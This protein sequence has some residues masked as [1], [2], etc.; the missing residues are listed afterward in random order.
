METVYW[1]AVEILDTTIR[2]R[3]RVTVEY[4]TR[5]M[6]ASERLLVLLPVLMASFQV[7]E[8]GSNSPFLRVDLIRFV[9]FYAKH[10]FVSRHG[11]F[12]DAHV[13]ACL[14]MHTYSCT[15]TH[16]RARAR[17]HARTHTHTQNNN[18]KQTN[19]QC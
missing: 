12:D 9:C 5:K 11:I 8:Y 13:H 17:T 16:T 3:C 7:G 14:H 2:T 4:K 15:H 10:V 19:K 18:N 6:A 1:I